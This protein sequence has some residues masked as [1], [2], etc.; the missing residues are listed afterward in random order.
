MLSR[1]GWQDGWFHPSVQC[2]VQVK[3]KKEGGGKEE[4]GEEEEEEGEEG[5]SASAFTF[6]HSTKKLSSRSIFSLPT[7]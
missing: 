4:E 3:K 6:T 2:L 5:E 7:Y 1:A